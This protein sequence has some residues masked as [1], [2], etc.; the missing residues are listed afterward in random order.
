MRC[1]INYLAFLFIFICLSVSVN[2]QEVMVE[3]NTADVASL[4]ALPGIGPK[5]AKAIIEYRNKKPFTR[6]S[7][8]VRVKGIGR[9]T[10]KK[11]ITKIKV[12]PVYYNNK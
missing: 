3:L 9:K 7:Q 4:C 2:A 6:V 8:L 11:L 10:L 12:E 1:R 5:K